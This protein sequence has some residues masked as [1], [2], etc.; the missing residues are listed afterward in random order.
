MGCG[1]GHGSR[2]CRAGN[3]SIFLNNTK[4]RKFAELHRLLFRPLYVYTHAGQKLFNGIGPPIWL[5]FNSS[6]YFNRNHDFLS[7]LQYHKSC[8]LQLVPYLI[9]INVSN[10]DGCAWGRINC[11]GSLK[12]QVPEKLLERTGE[13]LTTFVRCSPKLILNL[14]LRLPP[15]RCM[16]TSNPSSCEKEDTLDREFEFL[17]I[18]RIF[19]LWTRN[20][21]W[22]DVYSQ[23]SADWKG[24]CTGR[25]RETRERSKRLPLVLRK[26]DG[27]SVIKASCE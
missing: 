12:S 4:Y 22:R 23:L 26:S 10:D 1:T 18:E 8:I 17:V 16:E 6:L 24:Q 20:G 13:S 9:H 11:W 2:A 27:C 19:R 25:T 14:P 3:S 7:T 5:Q 21:K 15:F